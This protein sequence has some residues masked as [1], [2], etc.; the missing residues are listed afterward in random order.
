MCA[1]LAR[2]EKVFIKLII[3]FINNLIHDKVINVRIS[4]AILFAE[5]FP[6]KIFLLHTFQF[7][8]RIS[9]DVNQ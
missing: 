7:E 8:I 4:L 6:S 2:N 1:K 5:I 3:P 9:M